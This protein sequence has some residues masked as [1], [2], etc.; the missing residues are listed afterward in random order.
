MA[1]PRRARR[2]TGPKQYSLSAELRAV[3]LIGGGDGCALL[4]TSAGRE[5]LGQ[6]WLS[7]EAIAALVRAAARLGYRGGFESWAAVV[8]SMFTGSLGD[9]LSEAIEEVESHERGQQVQ[10]SATEPG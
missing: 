6:E 5:R 9:V 2:K 4:V 1:G 3:T 7:P 8:E 10:D